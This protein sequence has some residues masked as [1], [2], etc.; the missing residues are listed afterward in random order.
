MKKTS[1]MVSVLF[2]TNLF[3]M[4]MDLENLPAEILLEITSTDSYYSSMQ[5]LKVLEKVSKKLREKVY[6]PIIKA[7]ITKLINQEYIQE[8]NK[9]RLTD[10]NR[11][12]QLITCGAD[13]NKKNKLDND[14]LFEVV[15]YGDKYN[16]IKISDELLKNK[17]NVNSENYNQK[18]TP[19][20]AATNNLQ[21]EIITLLIKHGANINCKDIRGETALDYA[22]DH[23]WTP[24]RINTI[25]LLKSHGAKLGAELP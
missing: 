6:S 20:M 22:Y 25:N 12:I 2:F 18:V 5:I 15:G 3:A 10:W 17:A 13:I 4:Q 11:M 21:P 7:K 19:I 9:F 16:R 23:K 24:Q 14:A 8:F 1:L